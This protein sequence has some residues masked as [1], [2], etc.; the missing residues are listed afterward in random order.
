MRKRNKHQ[1]FD[2]SAFTKTRL[3]ARITDIR[4]EE[5][6]KLKI[7]FLILCEGQRTEPNYFHAIEKKLPKYIVVSIF[8]EGANTLSV[9]EKAIDMQESRRANPTQPDFDEVWAVFDRDSFP[10]ERVNKAIEVANNNDIEC[11]FSNEAFELW[12]LLHFIYFDAKITR[13]QYVKMLNEQFSKAIGSTFRYGKNRTDIYLLLKRYGREELAIRYAKRLEQL[14][15][16]ETPA[17]A[18][19]STSVY[20]LIERLNEYIG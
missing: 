7:F 14:H 20:K 13:E 11:A 12:Y 9:V 2:F 5:A 6:E 1:V 3:A 18:K 8:G 15:I 10:A 17:N 19:P 4:K 16:D